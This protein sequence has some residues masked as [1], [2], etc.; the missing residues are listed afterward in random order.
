MVSKVVTHSRF[1]FKVRMSLL[2]NYRVILSGRRV[3]ALCEGGGT[4][5]ALFLAHRQFLG[6]FEGKLGALP[7][8]LIVAAAAAGSG[9]R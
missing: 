2:Q 6:E 8:N 5:H 9:I 7:G 4:R 3:E 1:S